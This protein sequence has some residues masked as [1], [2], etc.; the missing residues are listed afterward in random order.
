[1]SSAPASQRT[2]PGTAHSKL[3]MKLPCPA[4]PSPPPACLR[5][6]SWLLF[7]CSWPQAA[8]LR[9][10]LPTYCHATSLPRYLRPDRRR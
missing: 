4:P 2:C 6:I 10:W 5:H 3:L 1:M 7:F 8:L 9:L